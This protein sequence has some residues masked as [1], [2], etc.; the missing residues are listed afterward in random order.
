MKFNDLGGLLKRARKAQGL[1]QADLSDLSGA[2]PSVIYKLESG[3][4][5]IALG[6]LLSVG[7]ALGVQIQ[8]KS[9]LGEEARLNG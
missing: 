3:R 7:D 1:T 6:S 9:P 4:E 5:D 8:V 2:S